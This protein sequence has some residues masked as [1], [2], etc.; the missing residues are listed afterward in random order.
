MK[1]KTPFTGCKKTDGPELIIRTAIVKML[2]SK[3]WYAIIT[4][5]NLFQSGLP[6]IFATHSR[7]G[8]RWIEVKDPNRTGDVFTAAQHDVFPKICANGSGVWVLIGDSEAE[9][10]KLFEKGNWYQYL[11]IWTRTKGLG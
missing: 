4:H 10:Q 3:G 2:A 8:A 11:S 9:Y 6:D 1:L 7:Y 5:G